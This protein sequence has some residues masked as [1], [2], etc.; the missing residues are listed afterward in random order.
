MPHYTPAELPF[1]EGQIS[2]ISGIVSSA[3]H[4]KKPDNLFIYGKV[5]TGKT[6]TT[7]YVIGQLEEF[8]QQQGKNVATAYINCR[9][10][11]SKYKV[12]LK[13]LKRFYPNDQFIGFSSSFVYEKLLEYA[14]KNKTHLLLVLD[15]VDM[16]KDLDELMYTLTR[17]N[18]DMENATISVIGISN[19]VLFK[20][21]L[22]ARTKSSLCEREIVFPPYNA[23]ELKAILKQRTDRA[24][25]EAMVDDSALSLAAAIA[26]KQSGDARTAVMLLLR[27]GEIADMDH[28]SHISDQE[29]QRAK[30][31]VEEEIIF[32]MLSTLP[33]HQQIV[34][35]AISVMTI[36]KQGVRKISGT[37]EDGVFFSGDVFE[38]YEQTAKKLQEVPVSTRWYRQYISDLEVSGLIITTSSGKGIR[39]N[40][41]LIKLGFDPVKIKE[42]LEGELIKPA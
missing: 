7:K 29:V 27:A 35:Y 20:D 13:C 33:H 9:T 30:S 26:A 39:G 22:D 1:R 19:N 24:F 11:N 25:K 23:P 8:V 42:A 4:D 5:G 32:S 31:K 28:L 17:C 40:T 36:T 38:F 16:T 12:M 6:V 41:T 37:Q 34:L 18:D 15:E 10:Y 21:K 2:E 14:E 3:L